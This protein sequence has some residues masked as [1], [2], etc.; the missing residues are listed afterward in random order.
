[1][2]QIRS[3]LLGYG[4]IGGGQS[5]EEGAGQSSIQSHADAL[6]YFEEIEWC[7][8]LDPSEDA[9]IRSEKRHKTVPFFKSIDEMGRLIDTIDLVVDASP[10]GN[11]LANLSG[12]KNVKYFFIEKPTLLSCSELG[13]DIANKKIQV[14]YW[15][16]F[17]P[18]YIELSGLINSGLLGKIQ[19]SE[20]RYGNGL[21]NNGSHMIDFARMLLG[22]IDDI[23]W[24]KQIKIQDNLPIPNDKNADFILNMKGG[25]P[26]FFKAL[27]FN[28][29]RENSI[30][31]TGSDMEIEIAHEG[32]VIYKRGRRA[33]S[34]VRDSFEMN[35]EPFEII[36]V[37][38]SNYLSWAYR[39]LINN[40]LGQEKELS[41][42]SQAMISESVVK[43]VYE[44][45]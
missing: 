32:A 29:F 2:K 24:S 10:P 45:V 28:I 9:K 26:I 42:L 44:S 15:R 27:D 25:F 17:A 39:S 18:N 14:N 35:L 20:I 13:G 22:E 3:L 5:Y 33:H 38:V 41:S 4:K 37:D 30:R 34:S 8:I 21:L 36:N 11:R 43:G 12:F 40:I 1:M 31:I 7:G 6:N 19:Y 23:E 16:R